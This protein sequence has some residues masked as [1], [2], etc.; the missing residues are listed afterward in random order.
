[1]TRQGCWGLVAE[2]LSA[3]DVK[4]ASPSLVV[5]MALD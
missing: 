5:A 2:H 3:A 4:G 1:M